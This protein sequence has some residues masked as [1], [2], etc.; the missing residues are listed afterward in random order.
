MKEFIGRKV[1][2]ERSTF[3]VEMIISEIKNITDNILSVSGRGNNKGYTFTMIKDEL[4]KGL[5]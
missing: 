1:K 2:V 5:I 3:D 4:I